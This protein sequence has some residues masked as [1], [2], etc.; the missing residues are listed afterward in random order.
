M[1][2]F[3][4]KRS[5][6]CAWIEFVKWIADARMVIVLCLC[7]FIYSFAVEPIKANAE[8]MG[9]P[10]NALEPFIAALNSGMILLIIPLGFITLI[11]DYPKIDGSTIFYIFR[12]GKK[13]WLCGQILRLLMMTAAYIWAIFAASVAGVITD[14]FTGEEWSLVATRFASEFPEQSGNFGVQLLPENLYN[15]MTLPTAVI[16]STLF[17][18]AYLFSL[19]MLL[20][21]FSIAKRK[22][23]GIVVCGLVIALGAAFCSIRTKLMWALPMAHSIVWLHYTEFLREPIFPVFYSAIYFAAIIAAALIFCMISLKRF[24]YDIISLEVQF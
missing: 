9:E 11:S 5:F 12:I 15:Q 6:S 13:S 10:M 23:A 4:F 3:S 1:S 18:V 16:E 2:K 17:V 21:A 24:D 7:V 22:T 14:G 19:G 8:L 20:L